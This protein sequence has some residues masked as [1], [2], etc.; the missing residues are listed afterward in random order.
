MNRLS[1]AFSYLLLLYA[2]IMLLWG[3]LGFVEYLAGIILLVPFQNPTFP[4]GTQFIH[5]LLI[6]LAGVVYL[7]GYFTKWKYT[8]LTMVIVFSM[9][10]TMV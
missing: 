8:P 5:W 6:T 9:L 10:A 7:A 3:I 4:A 1:I 2:V